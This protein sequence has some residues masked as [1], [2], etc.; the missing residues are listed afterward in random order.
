MA[1]QSV[2]KT[3]KRCFNHL[4]LRTVVETTN[5]T[6]DYQGNQ[7]VNRLCGI[8]RSRAEQQSTLGYCA[9]L[10]PGGGEVPARHTDTG[11]GTS[12]QV[13]CVTP[14]LNKTLSGTGTADIAVLGRSWSQLIFVQYNVFL[15]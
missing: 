3:V 7:S 5:T 14:C 11:L 8:S 2:N 9:F 4:L 1:N 6:V 10:S 13:A 15:N 12:S